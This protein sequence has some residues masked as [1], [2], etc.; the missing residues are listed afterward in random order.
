[1]LV[2]TGLLI[3]DHH[4]VVAIDMQKPTLSPVIKQTLFPHVL[5]SFLDNPFP[6]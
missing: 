3:D 2:P 1:M 4:P 5:S 6:V